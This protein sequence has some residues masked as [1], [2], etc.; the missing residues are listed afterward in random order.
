MRGSRR[1]P[2]VALGVIVLAVSA[3]T[4]DPTPAPTS[5]AAAPPTATS[6][7]TPPAGPTPPPEAAEEEARLP[8]APDDIAE[9]AATAVPGPGSEGHVATFSGWMSEHTAAHHSTTD[10]RAAPGDYQLQIA[11]R[12]EGTVTVETASGD[13]A[14]AGDPVVCANATIAFDAHPTAPGLVTELDLEGGPTV[15]AVSYRLIAAA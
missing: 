5:P 9:W 1:W 6:T 15:Y 2:A 11:C 3:C 14:P 4:A 7:R 10:S 13:G 12:G 8:I